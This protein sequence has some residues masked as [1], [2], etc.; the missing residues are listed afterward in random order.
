MVHPIN[1]N[2]PMTNIEYLEPVRILTGLNVHGSICHHVIP[3]Y[4]QRIP[5]IQIH[6]NLC[7]AATSIT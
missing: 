7:I 2:K 5:Q 1:L 3:P 4:S 6:T